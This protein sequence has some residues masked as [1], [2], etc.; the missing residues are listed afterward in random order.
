MA[1]GFDDPIAVIQHTIRLDLYK[2]FYVVRLADGSF[3]ASAFGR[4][5]DERVAYVVLYPGAREH[6]KSALEGLRVMT[7]KKRISVP[8]YHKEYGASYRYG[9]GDG[10]AGRRAQVRSF[11]SNYGA[12]SAYV[13]GW[14]KGKEEKL[15]SEVR[16]E[17]QSGGQGSASQR[18]EPKER[19]S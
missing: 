4:R 11:F 19:D 7:P 18:S 13:A 9:H 2:T 17:E 6:F 1:T 3:T 5:G 10:F 12:H 8:S 15:E 14:N 16:Q